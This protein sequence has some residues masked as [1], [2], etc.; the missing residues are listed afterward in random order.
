[1]QPFI[2]CTAAVSYSSLGVCLWLSARYVHVCVLDRLAFCEHICKQL[3]YPLW[4]QDNLLWSEILE[5]Q[6]VSDVRCSHL[7]CSASQR[8]RLQAMSTWAKSRAVRPYSARIFKR[9]SV[10][11]SR[12]PRVCPWLS[13]LST[14]S[15][16]PVILLRMCVWWKSLDCLVCLPREHCAT[17]Q[18]NASARFCWFL[19][20]KMLASFLLQR[21]SSLQALSFGAMPLRNSRASLTFKH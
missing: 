18:V 10:G 3:L 13:Y 1:M 14:C 16:H 4:H 12:R 20:P 7:P 8:N 19:S 5:V 15:L 2:V 9:S 6:I 11:S 21:S 17:P